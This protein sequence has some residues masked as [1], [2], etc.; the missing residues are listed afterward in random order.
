M[1]SVR[2]L[3][4]KGFV[5]VSELERQT[6][7]V[8]GSEAKSWLNGLLTSDVLA[9]TPTLGSYGLLL[10]KQGKIQA[11][12]DIVQAGDGLLLG[13]SA[14]LGGPVQTLLERYLIME[15]A[16]LSL[17][18]GV[19]WLR[20]HGPRAL[21]GARA[22][23]AALGSGAIDWLG[24]GGAAVAVRE[25]DVE[26]AVHA[27]LAAGGEHAARLSPEQ[28]AYLRIARAFPS[29]GLDYTDQDNPHEAGLER[30]AVSWTKGCYLGQEVVCMQ[31]MRGR[32]KRRLAVLEIDG[33]APV[34]PASPVES[35]AEAEAVGSVTSS[36]GDGEHSVALA[37][38]RFPFFEGDRGF[39]VAGRSARIIA[40]ETR[41]DGTFSG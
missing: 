25:T 8:R 40:P 20:L 24:L 36:A 35:P 39:D 12:L 13:V 3:A 11:E 37:R 27:S 5:L 14:G 10:S 33:S 17:E 32:V 38:L 4:K 1:Q 23:E 41:G 9:V 21:E 2:A 18:A 22:I 28:W 19:S 34:L 26:G 16:E 31:D 7:R 29:Y 30:R 15:D 6:L